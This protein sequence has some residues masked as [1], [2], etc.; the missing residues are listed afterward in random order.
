M[1]LWLFVWLP[2]IEKIWQSMFYI[3]SLWV[4]NRAFII[5]IF[6]SNIAISTYFTIKVIGLKAVNRARACLK[7]VKVNAWTRTIIVLLIIFNK[8]AVASM[9]FLLLE[10]FYFCF[11]ILVFKVIKLEYLR[12]TPST[13]DSIYEI[14]LS[15]KPKTILFY[16]LATSTISTAFV[17]LLS[18]YLSKLFLDGFYLPC[19]LL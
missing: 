4:L 3:L 15:S 13:L 12:A 1:L 14:S 11:W 16:N 9:D 2:T 7:S 8:I 5:V 18:I 19:K 10:L 6:C 17:F